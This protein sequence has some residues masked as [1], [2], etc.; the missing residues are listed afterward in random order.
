MKFF[1]LLYS[2]ITYLF[3]TCIFTYLVLFIGGD[4]LQA[5]VPVLGALKTVNHG[6][7]WPE[8]S[9]GQAI[10]LNSALLLAFSVHHSLMARPMVKRLLV[11][12]I[13]KSAE[14]S[15]FVLCSCSLLLAMYLLWQ[16]VTTVIW[17]VD[18]MA[19]NVMRVV[20]LVGAGLVLW[21]TFMIS[22]WRLFG[23]EQAWREFKGLEEPE[24]EFETPSLYKYYRHPMYVGILLVIWVTPIMTVG[25]LL[26]AGI[27][28]AYVLIGIY[29]EERDL[30]TLFGQRY[31]DYQKRVS[32]LFPLKALLGQGAEDSK[33]DSAPAIQEDRHVSGI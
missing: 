14:R 6:S 11:R 5:W 15:T 9:L 20:F 10:L 16:P 32:K 1:R 28:T 19:A 4:F 27:W 25:Q 24:D 30:V 13:P 18:G 33:T 21:A 17:Q 29:F 2:A 22:H 3:F 31:L 7:F 26:L 8:L 12:I 23:L